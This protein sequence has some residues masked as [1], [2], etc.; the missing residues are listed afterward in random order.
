[1]DNRLKIHRLEDEVLNEEKD[2]IESYIIK[3]SRER[4]WYE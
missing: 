3:R 4:Q 1:M 2:K